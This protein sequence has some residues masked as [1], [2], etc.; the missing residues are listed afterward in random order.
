MAGS[1]K[2]LVVQI[3]GDTSGLQK[4]LTNVNKSVR[5]LGTELNAI[6]KQL[7]FD[8][9]NTVLLSQKQEVLGEKIIV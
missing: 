4:A 1:V 6:N 3:G 7:Q 9:K 5:S 2:G 8:P